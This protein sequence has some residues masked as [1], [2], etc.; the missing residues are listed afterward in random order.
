ML[1]PFG[2]ACFFNYLNFKMGYLQKV[3]PDF[4]KIYFAKLWFPNGYISLHLILK[5]Y[6]VNKLLLKSTSFTQIGII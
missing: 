6:L 1:Y 5:P 2:T 4:I 3:V